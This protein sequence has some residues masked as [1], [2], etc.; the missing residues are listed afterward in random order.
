[1]S[2]Q[3]PVL[4]IDDREPKDLREAVRAAVPDAEVRRLSIGDYVI[5]DKEGHAL[6]IE[7]KSM[8]D[9][10][11]SM[12]DN[13]LRNQ[14]PNLAAFDHSMLLLEGCWSMNRD[15]LLVVPTLKGQRET[16]WTAASA[17]MILLGH[18]ERQPKLVTLHTSS[19][20]ESVVILKTLSARARNGCVMRS[21]QVRDRT[22]SRS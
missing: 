8:S 6:A 18:Q 13:R 22:R 16:K 19:P 21:N 4:L 3:E 5:L 20:R 11:H 7:R 1:M 10:L 14:I 2:L 12:S 15:H 17:Q 9:L